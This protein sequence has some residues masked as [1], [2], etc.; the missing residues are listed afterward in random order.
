[1]E[2]S[3]L[4]KLIYR[5]CF[6]IILIQAFC[7]KVFAKTAPSLSDTIFIYKKS[8]DVIKLWNNKPHSSSTTD[9]Q[10][11]TPDEIID[12]SLHLG[13][14]CYEQG[15]Y[16]K[17]IRH[18][19]EAI[20]IAHK[21]HCETKEI[22]A[23]AEISQPLATIGAHSEA[24]HY[25]DKAWEKVKVTDNIKG[26]ALIIYNSGIVYYYQ[27]MN[28]EA[29]LCYKT[30]LAIYKSVGDSSKISSILE[31][32]GHIYLRNQQHARALEHYNSS[33]KYAQKFKNPKAIGTALISLGNLYSEV[34]Q[35]ATAITY[36]IEAKKLF[37]N[38]G[39]KTEYLR[40]L[41]HMAYTYMK[42]KKKKQAIHYAQ[43]SY[44]MATQQK[45]LYYI[46]TSA[47]LLS[48]LHEQV[49]QP[50]RALDYY[51]I[52]T[53]AQE[54]LYGPGNKEEVVKMKDKYLFEKQ[55]R[56]IDLAFQ[57]HLYK[58]EMQIYIAFIVISF[59]L[60]L[61]ILLLLYIKQKKK[62]NKVLQD[63]KVSIEEQNISLKK[64]N[65]FK[66][67]LLSVMAHD[68]RTPLANAKMILSLFE[69]KH[70]SKQHLQKLIQ[71]SQ[72]EI[73]S[74]IM[75]LDNLLHWITF[76][77]SKKKIVKNYFSLED[78]T[79]ETFSLFRR[80][81]AEKEVQLS[82]HISDNL[83]IYGDI[84]SLKTVLRNLVSNAIKFSRKRGIVTVT[85]EYNKITHQTTI[86]IIDTGIGISPSDLDNLI[87]NPGYSQEGTK[88]EKGTGIG[89]HL[90]FQYISLNNSKL[91][92]K[93]SLENGTEI[94][95]SLKGR[96]ASQDM[97]LVCIPAQ[98]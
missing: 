43:L 95:F 86:R 91:F 16:S 64:S 78:I 85:S 66:K 96:I 26:R 69:R 67:Q 77:L 79:A 36:Y 98:V 75:L 88:H 74:L 59:L 11:V 2:N 12:A 27:S 89:L 62:I 40:L 8:Q 32:I 56:K 53:A 58:K 10:I 80:Q 54:S 65:A 92:I 34:G 19:R 57:K 61:A 3:I 52:S 24:L 49:K 25:L 94:W 15:E 7:P 51:K 1:M 84:E 63:A 31:S 82:M 5:H 90:C 13:A 39:E 30:S 35:E 73:D 17:A 38:L 47:M 44:Y 33:L 60:I 46:K 6:T 68:I 97:P 72:I 9:D 37:E 21:Y 22:Q 87:K 20:K 81:A 83:E 23:M 14:A 42:Q 93:S 76:Q 29:L 71:S 41:N 70:V 28:K 4:K 45:R 18:Y 48:K 50:E 55:R